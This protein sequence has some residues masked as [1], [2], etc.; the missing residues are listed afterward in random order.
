MDTSAIARVEGESTR[1]VVL[2]DP[3]GERT[4][5]NAHRCRETGPPDRIA[6]LEID[7]LYVR[8]RE[9]D[10]ADL[11]AGI[12]AR[13]RVVA[14]LPPLARGTRPAH[15]LVGSESDLPEAFVAD[16][17]DAGEGIAGPLLEWVVMTMGASTWP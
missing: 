6:D 10:L 12:G 17:W 14:H 16:P 2:V 11:M 8:S 15:V 9:L 4:I 5:V 13:A 7:A 1:S 3:E